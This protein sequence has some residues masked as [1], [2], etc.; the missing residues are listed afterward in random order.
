[1]EH[2]VQ[3]AV[4][5]DDNAIKKH[6]EEKAY[7]DILAKLY[8]ECKTSVGKSSWGGGSYIDWKA[9]AN[10]TLNR[11]IEEHKDEIIDAASEK[12]KDSFCRSKAYKEKMKGILNEE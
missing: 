9:M 4:G 12:L 3:F 7:D 10:E 5:I 8:S 1:M 6:V 11:F 2:I